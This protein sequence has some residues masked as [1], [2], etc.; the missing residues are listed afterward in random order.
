ME[1]GVAARAERQAIAEFVDEFVAVATARACWE[2]DLMR[3]TVI[4]QGDS[5]P[6]G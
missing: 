6:L 3:P 2:R 4:D 5:S 1:D